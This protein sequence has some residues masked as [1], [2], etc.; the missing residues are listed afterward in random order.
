MQVCGGSHWHKKPEGTSSAFGTLEADP[1]AVGIASRDD[2]PTIPA[3]SCGVSFLMSGETEAKSDSV[4]RLRH[5][6]QTEDRVTAI[7]QFRGQP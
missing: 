4:T 6:V 1:K 3:D 2:A 5:H 7:P